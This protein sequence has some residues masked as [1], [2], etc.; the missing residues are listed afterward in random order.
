MEDALTAS[1]FFGAALVGLAGHARITGYLA[2]HRWLR[3]AAFAAAFLLI[4]SILAGGP[5]H[6]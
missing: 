6:P 5:H 4:A 3:V 2:E 1:A